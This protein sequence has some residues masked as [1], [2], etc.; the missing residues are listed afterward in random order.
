MTVLQ[1]ACAG[2]LVP[3]LS[4]R[5]R[6]ERQKTAVKKTCIRTRRDIAYFSLCQSEKGDE[7]KEP[8]DR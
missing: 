6:S 3:F 2:S 8:K 7:E 1:M 5:R 4:A